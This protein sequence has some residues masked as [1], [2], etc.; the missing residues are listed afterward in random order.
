L[1]DAHRRIELQNEELAAL[2][3][4]LGAMQESEALTETTPDIIETEPVMPGVDL[5]PEISIEPEIGPEP[6]VTTPTV[7]TTPAEPTFIER[8]IGFLTSWGLWI[9]GGLALIAVLVVFLK[10]RREA[11]DEEPVWEQADEMELPELER[12]SAGFATEP[13]GLS[14]GESMIVVERD[15]GDTITEEIIV[16][17][18]QPEPIRSAEETHEPLV[19]LSE[20][21][22]EEYPFEQTLSDDTALKLQLDESDVMAEADFHMAYGLYDQASNLMEK[23]VEGNP[24]RNDYRMKLVEIYF[25]WGN[26]EKF[27]ESASEFKNAVGATGGDW[28][29]IM[30]MGKQICPDE[31]LFAGLA[32]L[33]AGE[34]VDLDLAATQYATKV[35]MVTE[36]SGEEAIDLDFGADFGAPETR[37]P[38]SVD[39]DLETTGETAMLSED[40]MDPGD[41]PTSEV[42]AFSDESLDLNLNRE[43]DFSKTSADV[44]DGTK[45]MQAPD[46]D[47]SRDE[48][49]TAIAAKPGI[50][51]GPDDSTVLSRAV[52]GDE[53]TVKAE[54]LDTSGDS[55]LTVKAES[56][57]AAAPDQDLTVK[58]E[59]L[60][61]D[62]ESTV[63]RTIVMDQQDAIDED[64][65]QTQVLRE[66]TYEKTQKIPG[67]PADEI[68]EVGTKLDLARAFMDM[69]DP[70]G[71]RSILNEVLVEGSDAQK[72]EARGLIDGLR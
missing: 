45:T 10:R 55:D 12:D 58:A 42:Q 28:D 47:L 4:Q 25:I 29:K 1:G 50:S 63:I 59:S 72:S 23:A 31:L 6:A 52:P 68:D 44:G 3:A 38:L 9:L 22:D 49:A 60:A 54:S 2:Q 13:I 56:A 18:V 26:K 48:D 27:L 64:T 14:E 62:E 8:A 17:E 32:A 71:A 46:I 65:Q 20:G 70:D 43:T 35:D 66:D 15:P 40:T 67:R 7:T 34:A 37:Q 19:D 24:D 33:S 57:G 61:D 53:P 11:E 16:P 36:D 51:I 21:E 39:I 30:I 5:E 69:G 41:E